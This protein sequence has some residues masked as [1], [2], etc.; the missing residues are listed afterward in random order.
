MAG[1]YDSESAERSLFSVPEAAR[2][3]VQARL[4]ARED[5]GRDRY[6]VGRRMSRAGGAR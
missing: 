1:E 4:G 6:D 5:V 2:R 3:A